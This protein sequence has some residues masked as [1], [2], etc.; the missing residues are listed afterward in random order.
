MV[1]L[2]PYVKEQIGHKQHLDSVKKWSG[3][4]FAKSQTFSFLLN[5]CL[6]YFNGVRT[7]A[8]GY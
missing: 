2:D 7:S 8:F 3:L 6:N 4:G 1:H 5:S